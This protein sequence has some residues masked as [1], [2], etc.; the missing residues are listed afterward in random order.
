MAG[1]LDQGMGTG[2]GLLAGL[3]QYLQQN[4]QTVLNF[5]AG[6]MNDRGGGTGGALGN[7]FSTLGP[8]MTADT[9]TREAQ[10]RKLALQKWLETQKGAIPPALAGVVS[11]DPILMRQVAM[12]SIAPKVGPQP[13]ADIQNFEYGQTHPAFAKLAQGGYRPATPDEL[14]TYGV[15]PGTPLVFGPNGKPEII[16]GVNAYGGSIFNGGGTAAENASVSDAAFGPPGSRNEDV[17]SKLSPETAGIVKGLANYELDPSKISSTRGNQRLQ[18]VAA[19]KAYDPN[20]DMTQYPARAAMRKSITSG[21]YSQALNSANLVIQHLDALSKS[22]DGLNNSD[23]K[24]VNV[25]RNTYKN[26][27]GDPAITKFNTARDAAAAELAKVFK[28]TGA[29]DVQSIQEWRNNLDIN[30]SPAQIRQS[31]ATAVGDLLKSRIDTIQNQFQAAMGHPADFSYLTPH[32]RQVLT[33]LGIDPASLDPGAATTPRDPFGTKVSGKD[34]SRMG[35]P[36]T[37]NGYT[38]EQAD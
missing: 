5:A 21:T 2:G 13:T 20:F 19:A 29:S 36:V 10:A 25:V 6:L 4:P 22:I 1:I 35:Q 12:N 16:G 7:A 9:T 24:P 31:I 8:S 18:L 38:I 23:L 11:S 37:I 14:K 33:D 32:S 26:Q 15:A 17:L 34:Q 27:T 28:G 3:Q 30:G